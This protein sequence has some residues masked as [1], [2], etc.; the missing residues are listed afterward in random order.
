MLASQ[1]PGKFFR[2]FFSRKCFSVRLTEYPLL[3]K[4]L[5][6]SKISPK[7]E[8]FIKKQA[9]ERVGRKANRQFGKSGQTGLTPGLDDFA[10]GLFPS[11][12]E[13]IAPTTLETRLKVRTP[14][15]LPHLSEESTVPSCP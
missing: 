1:C 14:L 13:G 4:S 6:K 3:V 8:S 11:H 10:L 9:R 5:R 12:T 15:S 2:R 7:A